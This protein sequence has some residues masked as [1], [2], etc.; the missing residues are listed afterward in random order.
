M[1]WCACHT[2][3][4]KIG[5]YDPFDAMRE[6]GATL[7]KLFSYV[8]GRQNRDRL[9]DVE[10]A[11]RRG[12]LGDRISRIERLLGGVRLAP[13]D[14]QS[15]AREAMVVEIDVLKDLVAKNPITVDF[16]DDA[17]S[18]RPTQHANLGSA[19]N[20][21]SLITAYIGEASRAS[22][23]AKKDQ[24]RWHGMLEEFVAIIGDKPVNRYVSGD[25][26]EFKSIQLNLP[27]RRHVDPFRG[28]SPRECIAVAE[29]VEVDGA[30]VQ[31]LST[32][33]V[34][35]KIGCVGRF[36]QWARTRYPDAENPVAD[37]KVARPKKR[38]CKAG[39]DSVV[40]GRAQHNVR[41]TDLHGSA[42]RKA[43]A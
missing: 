39:S 17:A 35:D 28:K 30:H 12:Q 42:E 3:S 43:V 21:A 22:D 8:I 38:N 36:F 4:P 11:Y 24:I 26:A 25:G 14:A 1:N 27:A 33:T 23:W 34:K 18:E 5:L 2:G 20:M 32:S 10:S 40:R 37:I 41:F 13:A 16:A 29:K 31:R 9:S 19:P 15:L 6:D 7:E